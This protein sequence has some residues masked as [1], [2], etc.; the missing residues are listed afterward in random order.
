MRNSK[1]LNVCTRSDILMS[2]IEERDN[3]I[4]RLRAFARFIVDGYPRIGTSHEEFRVQAYTNACDA[5]GIEPPV[6][7]LLEMSD[8]G[9]S[10]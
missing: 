4:E 8:K 6:L 1:D 3:E 10:K 2:E 5:L 9:E 7:S